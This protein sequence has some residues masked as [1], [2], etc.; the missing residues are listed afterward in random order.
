VFDAVFRSNV[1]C[2]HILSKTRSGIFHK[3]SREIQFQWVRTPGTV[4][5]VT[6][7]STI[8]LE[9]NGR[10]SLLKSRNQ[11]VVIHFKTLDY[12]NT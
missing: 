12:E 2:H 10:D 5:A 4:G 7:I 8:S 3:G 6:T 9:R 1:S 11:Q